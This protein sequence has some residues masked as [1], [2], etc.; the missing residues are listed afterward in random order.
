VAAGFGISTP[1]QVG[2]L[3]GHGADGAI[4]GSAILKRIMEGEGAR[5]V[6]AYVRSLKDECR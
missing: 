5:K 4:V 6:C 3:R 2:Q 1:R